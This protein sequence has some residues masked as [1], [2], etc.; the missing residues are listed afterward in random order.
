MTARPRGN[1]T[2]R[3]RRVPVIKPQWRYQFS[4]AIAY[5]VPLALI[6]LTTYRLLTRFMGMKV[7]SARETRC[8]KCNH[9]LRGITEPRC[10][11]CGERI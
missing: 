6:A 5:G 3:K 8:R 9:I 10:P 2:R 7:G 11:E 1:F 4:R